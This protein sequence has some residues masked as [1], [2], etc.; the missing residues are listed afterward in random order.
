MQHEPTDRRIPSIAILGIVALVGG[1][2]LLSTL[3]AIGI[4]Y[5]L[6]Q[7]KKSRMELKEQMTPESIAQVAPPPPR[8]EFT[9]QELL[10]FA[11]K[12][13]EIARSE[14]YH[15]AA[16]LMDGDVFVETVFS[17]LATARSARQLRHGL[18]YRVHQLLPKALE[19]A[20]GGSYEF[21][22]IRYADNRP[23]LLFRVLRQ[24]TR[25]N[26]HEYLV[27]RRPSEPMRIVDVYVYATGELMSQSM[28][29]IALTLIAQQDKSLI[30][31]LSQSDRE[32]IREMDKV[33]QM[34]TLFEGG[35]PREALAIH[36]SLSPTLRLLKPLAILRI[37]IAQECG[38]SD[39]TSA[40]EDF[41]DAYPDDA[42]LPLFEVDYY[43]LRK[44]YDKSLEAVVRLD[45]AVGGDPY[46][47]SIA[48]GV[49]AQA[50]RIDDAKSLVEEAIQRL[51]DYSQNYWQLASIGLDTNDYQLV[52][53]TLKRIDAMFVVEWGDL[54]QSPEYVEFVRS[55]QHE[56]WLLYLALKGSE[57]ANQPP[58]EPS[59]PP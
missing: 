10:E 3:V 53:E 34:T 17:G 25:L 32:F 5:R 21:L 12:I 28:R 37:S 39:L 45:E 9:E 27:D 23:R 20:K 24:D 13:E 16:M 51:P 43:L 14:D 44:E 6:G 38:E 54:G 42:A 29:R 11:V 58:A 47:D 15:T 33:D 50:G 1:I 56:E 49:L 36:H 41:R 8:E 22:Q 26:Y 52:L 35:R 30:E 46:L 57:A 31:K 4:G 7:Q 2:L 55:P 59:S 40:V 19:A 48:A 18:E